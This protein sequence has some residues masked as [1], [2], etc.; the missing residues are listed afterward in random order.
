MTPSS[1]II[2]TGRPSPFIEPRLRLYRNTALLI[3][4][5]LMLNTMVLG[6]VGE[7]YPDPEGRVF[8]PVVP[9]IAGVLTVVVG[10][11]WL[12]LRMEILRPGRILEVELTGS[13][14]IFRRRGGTENRYS[15]DLLRGARA[16][17]R[18]GSFDYDSMCLT[19]LTP[20]EGGIDIADIDCDGDTV[21]KIVTEIC[22]RVAVRKGRADGGI[23]AGRDFRHGQK[24]SLFRGWKAK[25]AFYGVPAAFLFLV[26]MMERE[27]WQENEIADNGHMAAGSVLEV[28]HEKSYISVAYEFRDA[29]GTRYEGRGKVRNGKEP[30]PVP[31]SAIA[32]LYL[33]GNPE[34]SLPG[35][36]HRESTPVIRM[37]FWEFALFW[38][39]AGLFVGSGGDLAFIRGKV[40][41]LRKGELEEEWWERTRPSA[42]HS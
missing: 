4:S 34:R 22:A 14:V 11:V 29:A 8:W 38:L 28:Y 30:A 1:V 27:T 33:P 42:L 41:L 37:F 36:F 23:E 17:Y 9:F 15:L 3:W 12:L 7:L 2:D 10:G 5:A 16:V 21:E 39:L 26:L 40:A 20:G 6:V 25:F 24:R 19:L 32:V 31:G 35:E 13:Y 18:G